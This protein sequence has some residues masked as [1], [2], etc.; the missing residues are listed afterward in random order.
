MSLPPKVS[1]KYNFVPAKNSEESKLI[2]ILKNP[3]KW[4]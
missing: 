3:V 4:V 2:D 1:W